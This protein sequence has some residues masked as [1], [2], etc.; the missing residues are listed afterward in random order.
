MQASVL[1][2]RRPCPSRLPPPQAAEIAALQ[3]L[4][5]GCR[6]LVLVGDPQQ[7]PAT[8]FSAAAKSSLLERSLFERLAQ[9]GTPVKVSCGFLAYLYRLFVMW[10]LV[11]SGAKPRGACTP[12]NVSSACVA[13]RYLV[14]TSC[15]LE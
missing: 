11:R 6:H 15:A 3:P 4:L 5:Y 12:V 2:T 9:A 1:C 10:V 7:L 8:L 14:A 13:R